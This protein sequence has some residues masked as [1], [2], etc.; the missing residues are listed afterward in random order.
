MKNSKAFVYG[1]PDQEV[2]FQEFLDKNRHNTFVL[3]PSKDSISVQD[4]LSRFNIATS[5]QKEKSV[6]EKIES[7]SLEH[8]PPLNMIVLDGTWSQVYLNI[9]VFSFKE[10]KTKK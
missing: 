7:L 8:C 1:V 6:E 3:F 2:A 5:S 4:Y 10:K 9:P